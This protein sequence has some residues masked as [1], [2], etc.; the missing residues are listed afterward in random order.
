MFVGYT[1]KMLET[2]QEENIAKRGRASLGENDNNLPHLHCERRP[3]AAPKPADLEKLCAF[4]PGRYCEFYTSLSSKVKGPVT[5]CPWT[6][7]RTTVHEGSDV[8]TAS[9][10]SD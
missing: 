1:H 4:I 3:I 10:E 5:L 8:E 6:V 2:L 7:G 9:S